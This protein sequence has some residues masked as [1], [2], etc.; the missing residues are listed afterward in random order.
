MQC[1]DCFLESRASTVPVSPS[2]AAAACARRGAGI[3][4]RHAHATYA[5]IPGAPASTGAPEA[6]RI[7]CDPCY[8]AETAAAGQT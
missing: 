8:Q 6:R 1:Y 7:T 5:P 2:I 3:C 4:G